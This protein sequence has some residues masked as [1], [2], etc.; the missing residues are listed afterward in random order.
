MDKENN[1]SLTS[2]QFEPKDNRTSEEGVLSKILDKVKSAV[3]GQPTSWTHDN[4]SMH[5]THSE[6]RISNSTEPSVISI[7]HT[8][9]NVIA[10]TEYPNSS[11][12]S[13]TTSQRLPKD[14]VL[15]NFPVSSDSLSK[16]STIATTA[17]TVIV[18]KHGKSE[19]MIV[20]PAHS[21]S[22]VQF[23]MPSTSNSNNRKS[24]EENSVDLLPLYTRKSI[25]SDTQ[26]VATNFS[27]SNSNSLG[28]I[29]ARLRGQKNDKEF[30]MPDEQ[31]K[32]CYKCRKPFTL[33]RRKHHCRTCGRE[34][35][36]MPL[37]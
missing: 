31:C 18:G 3:S 4:A 15:A 20:E 19:D 30:W 16:S 36:G 2:F 34:I 29:L 26:S 11:S 33:L 5:S 13:S 22:T 37:F 7:P 8:V 28:R 9:S 24:L 23:I 27:I 35:E 17:T 1:N 14:S 10:V 21:N 12:N 32:E 25:D 6:R